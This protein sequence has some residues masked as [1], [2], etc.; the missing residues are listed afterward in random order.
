VFVRGKNSK[1]HADLVEIDRLFDNFS[2]IVYIY[3]M[4]DKKSALLFILTIFLALSC[5]T[6]PVPEQAQEAAPAPTTTV[7][8]GN[9]VQRT[10]V[11]NVEEE[12]N[13]N[14]I[15]REYYDATKD[16]VQHFIN[17]LNRIISNKDYNSWRAALSDSYFREIS[18]AENL[19][20]ISEQP[21]M[22]TRRIV[23]RTAEDYFM[24]VVVPSRANSR[25]DD[26]EF[27]S[28]YRVKAFTVNVSS[29]TGEEQRLRLYDL[30]KIGN[31][32]KI[33]N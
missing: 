19:Q 24:H 14:A 22:T 20:Q 28:R 32:W 16:E 12:F 21:A 27:V 25:V 5:G 18:S 31:T 6:K 3:S 23:L 11:V 33:I 4:G 30:E 2:V 26:I 8:Q 1:V 10:P 15:T 17:D 7:T 29:R 9:T 13:P